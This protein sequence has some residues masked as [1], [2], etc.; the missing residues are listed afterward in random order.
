MLGNISVKCLVLHLSSIYLPFPSIK[1]QGSTIGICCI[2]TPTFIGLFMILDMCTLRCTLIFSRLFFWIFK[3]C[4]VFCNFILF[5]NLLLYI[6]PLIYLYVLGRDRFFTVYFCFKETSFSSFW[7]KL[8]NKCLG[9]CQFRV[10][11]RK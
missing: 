2:H 8:F 5:K 3:K 4:L 9:V 1:M 10:P 7:Y 11:V 6:W